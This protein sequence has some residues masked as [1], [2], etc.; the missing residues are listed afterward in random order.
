MASPGEPRGRLFRKY[1][2][3]FA[4][5]VSGALLASGLTEI[6]FSY[7]EN[8]AALVA[9]QREKA[10]AAAAKIEQFIKEIERQ[11][12]WASQPQI[13][14]R[15]TLEQRRF[16][17]LRL[18]RQVPP[19]TEI[20]L[21]DGA[22]REQLKVSR[23]AMDVVGSQADF[24]REP[25]FLEAKP[26]RTYFGPVY[27]RKE[28]EPYITISIAGRGDDAGV[29]VA[30]V[31]LKFIWDVVSQIKVGQAGHAFV[32]D[33][34]GHLIAHPDISLVL[35]KTDLSSLAQVQAAR[36]RAGRSTGD[37]EEATIVRD[38]SGRQVLTASATIA[39]LGW[40][41]FVDLPRGE[42]FAP[43]YTSIY[44]TIVLVLLGVALSVLASLFLARR[45]V[46]PIRALQA[47]AARIGA[48]ALDQQIEV[49]TGDELEALAQQ[50]N[51]MAAELQGSYANLEQ[52][53]ET[54]TRELTEAL[55]QQTATAEI[56]RVISSSP[57]DIQPV[58]AAV[59]ESAAKL[60]D[61]SFADIFR[62]E[63]DRMRLVAR[64]GSLV[65]SLDVGKSR[66][67]TR[68]SVSGRAMLDRQLVHVPDALAE[69]ETEYPEIRATLERHGI[70]TML[71]I[72]LLREGVPIGAITILRLEV[73]PFSEKQI[74]LVKTFAAQAVIAIENVRLFQEL[75]AR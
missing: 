26:G 51:S 41:V 44:R 73:R 72:P 21:L 65:T 49:R 43:L 13:G 28:S 71:G 60:C 59:V 75:Q 47:G 37:D 34:R 50:F 58:L 25:K 56:L 27:F 31:N 30:E 64:H 33:V 69:P 10:L 52:K 12:G 14:V 1:V 53:V 11:V 67:I 46:T 32:V 6:Y 19:V 24:A 5:L 62:V 70:R 29:T 63:A 7:Q 17:F 23:L 20:S 35:Q 39:P 3:L 36:S 8:K 74:Q 61:A 48:G 45:M 18:L 42:A 54:R 16:D 57:T 4:S 68:G 2:V 22:G 55:E 66:A 9:L 15:A 40:L 38:V